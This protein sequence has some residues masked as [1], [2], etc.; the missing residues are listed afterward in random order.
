MIFDFISFLLLQET[1]SEGRQQVTAH[2]CVN[3]AGEILPPLLI[4][5]GRKSHPDHLVDRVA[6]Y[7][8]PIFLGRTE[9][10]YMT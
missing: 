6:E 2:I 10:G 9:K 7:D 1:A 8:T 5:P 3:A 4:Y